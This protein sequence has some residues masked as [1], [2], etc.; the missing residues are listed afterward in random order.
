MGLQMAGFLKRLVN[1]LAAEDE[2]VATIGGAEPYETISGSVGRAC[3]YPTAASK[4]WWGPP[5][6]AFIE[7]MPW[8]GTGHCLHQAIREQAIVNALTAQGLL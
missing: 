8:F 3:G 2:A 1:F 5:F 6:R 7:F 4:K